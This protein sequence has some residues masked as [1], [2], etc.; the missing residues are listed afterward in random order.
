MMRSIKNLAK[1]WLIPPGLWQS[2]GKLRVKP[3]SEHSAEDQALLASTR[4]L[5]DRHRGERCFILAAGSSIGQQDLKKLA[6]E[7]VISVSN[8]FVHPDYELIKPQYHVLPHLLRGH[9]RLRPAESFVE[10]LRQMESKTG[11]AEMFM[12]IGDKGL[13]DQHALFKERVIHWNEYVPWDGKCQSEIDLA[14][15]PSIWSV[16]EYAISVAIYLG[17]DEIYLLGFDHDWFNGLFV[18]FYDHNTEH[19]MKPDTEA[20]AYVDSEFQMRRHA[21][22]FKKYKCLREMKHNIYN[23]NANPNTYVD[24][25]PKV[26]Y[27][28]L[29]EGQVKA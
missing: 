13:V 26:D 11:N 14:N 17:F 21:D 20:L 3:A 12:H 4:Q 10:W 9:G 28:S 25:F 27:D 23:A 8:T 24:V 22:I 7:H 5:R 16:S 2:L 15:I 19:A 29:F 1:D 18:Y 6:G